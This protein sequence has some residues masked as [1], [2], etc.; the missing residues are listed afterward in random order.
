[1]INVDGIKERYLK[2]DLP[3]RLGGLAANLAR[4]RSIVVNRASREATTSL[5]EESKYFI[6]WAA[7]EATLATQVVLVEIQ[8]ELVKWERRLSQSWDDDAQR[9][10]LSQIAKSWSDQVL[11]LS[12]LLN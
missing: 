11:E 9:Q 3:V 6:E 7:P 4:I 12:G 2:D 5:I 8:R 10:D 1:M